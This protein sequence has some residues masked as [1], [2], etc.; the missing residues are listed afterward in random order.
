MPQKTKSRT[1]LVLA[2]L[3]AIAGFGLAAYYRQQLDA[4]NPNVLAIELNTG[5]MQKIKDGTSVLTYWTDEEGEHYTV[6]DISKND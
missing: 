6:S 2:S 1:P 5:K 4:H 3:S